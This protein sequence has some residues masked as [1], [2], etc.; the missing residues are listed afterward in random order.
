MLK[1]DC[2]DAPTDRRAA[3]TAFGL[4]LPYFTKLLARV[5]RPIL[6]N[7]EVGSE[8][9]IADV[10]MIGALRGS[11]IMGCRQPRPPLLILFTC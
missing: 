10:A 2:A 1:Q 8:H 6:A 3:T 7:Q 9:I 4:V 11:E 5:D